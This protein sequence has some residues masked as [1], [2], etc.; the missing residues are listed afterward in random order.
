MKKYTLHALLVLIL[1]LTVGCAM[2]TK[3]KKKTSATDSPAASQPSPQASVQ[4]PQIDAKKDA[5]PTA[6]PYTVILKPFAIHDFIE[7]E[8][9]DDEERFGDLLSI[10]VE[11]NQS[12]DTMVQIYVPDNNNARKMFITRISEKGTLLQKEYPLV[13]ITAP[14]NKGEVE[15]YQSDDHSQDIKRLY[16]YKPQIGAL[17]QH[18]EMSYPLYRVALKDHEWRME[19]IDQY[20]KEL[21]QL[22]PELKHGK[23]QKSE[24]QEILEYESVDTDALAHELFSS[25]LDLP[26][27]QAKLL[28]LHLETL[29]PLDITSITTYISIEAVQQPIE[30]PQENPNPGAT[31]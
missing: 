11:R 14:L 9:K 6:D 16:G 31:H 24:K 29:S 19:F 22:R 27:V 28:E 21:R 20:Y 26:E 7:I 4:P 13:R 12:A 30:F 15:A 25:T 23:K 3:G 5:T 17:F 1:T 18:R 10:R 8:L 2:D